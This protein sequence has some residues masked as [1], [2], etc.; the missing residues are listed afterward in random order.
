MSK[1]TRDWF[2]I[3]LAFILSCLVFYGYYFTTK[4]TKLDIVYKNWDG[5]SYVLAAISLYKPEVAYQNNFINSGDIR[6]DWTWLPA[7]FPLYPL[8]IRAFSF[9]GYFQ[10]MLLI[11]IGFALLCYFALYDLICS[12]RISKN[13]LLLTLPFIFLSPRWFIVSHTGGSESMF[14]FFILLFLRYLYQRNHWRAAIFIALA[15]LARPQAAFFGLGLAV[16]ALIE[17][18]RSHDLKKI[19]STYYPYLTIP[20][21]LLLVFCFYR[22]Q[23]GNFWAFFNA[24]SLTKNLQSIPFQTFSFPS[25]NIETFWQEVNAYDYVLY[26]GAC[27]F[28]FRKKLWQFGILGLVYFIPLIFLQHSDISRYAI[29][30]L[31]FAFIAYSEIIEKREFSLATLLMS[32]AVMLYAINFMDHNHGI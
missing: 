2:Y 20:L 22:L 15:Q 28:M 6:S 27:L 4:G 7:H 10:A 13:P 31:P 21:S 3:T 24:I 12:L 32:P 18:L 1:I 9:L 8:L 16:V 23:T 5:P 26:L 25:T 19:I 14:L 29:P 30:L 11:S 17:L